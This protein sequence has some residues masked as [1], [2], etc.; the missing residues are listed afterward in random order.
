VPQGCLKGGRRQTLDNMRSITLL[1]GVLLLPSIAGFVLLATVHGGRKLAE[2]RY[3][4]APGES[5]DR[6]GATL[7]RLRA[8]LEATEVRSGL[9]AK[10][11]RI[12]ALRGAYLDAL[13]DACACLEVS[14]PAG[15]DRASQAEIYRTE[16]ALRERGL[17]VRETA[18]R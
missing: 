17:D 3:Q 2:S 6:L 4:P 9:T 18:A 8:E 15:G 13:G 12:R 10:N 11:H 16:A 7:R 1:I 5:A 14:P